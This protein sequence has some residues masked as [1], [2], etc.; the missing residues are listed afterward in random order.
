VTGAVGVGAAVLLR[1]GSPV[2]GELV[3]AERRGRSSHLCDGPG[4]LAQA[5]GIDQSLNGIDLLDA[6]SPVRL[7]PD[8]S[9]LGYSIATRIGISRATDRMLRFG[10]LEGEPEGRR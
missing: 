5:M 1:G 3:M 7:L 2:A 6:G 9:P 10:I 8:P 4:K